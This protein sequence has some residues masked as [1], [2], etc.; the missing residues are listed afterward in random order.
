MSLSPCETSANSC[1]TYILPADCLIHG[2]HRGGHVGATKA[3][4]LEDQKQNFQFHYAAV[5][6]RLLEKYGKKTKKEKN[7][8]PH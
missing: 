3:L 1:R 5:K 7:D 8:M 6:Y 4:R 2:A